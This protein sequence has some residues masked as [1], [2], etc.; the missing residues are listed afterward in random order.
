MYSKSHY[1]W[2]GI[3]IKGQGVSY[4]YEHD[5]ISSFLTITKLQGETVDIKNTT[6]F[7][8]GTEQLSFKR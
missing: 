5:G 6:Y 3:L 8:H 7:V 4:A 2:L 1:K